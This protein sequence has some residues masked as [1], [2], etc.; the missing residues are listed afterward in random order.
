LV[1]DLYHIPIQ[2]R[3]YAYL[4]NGVPAHIRLDFNGQSRWVDPACLLE[5]TLAEGLLIVDQ[6]ISPLFL[7]LVTRDVWT[8][9]EL[10]GIPL[11]R[12]IC[13]EKGHPI[14]VNQD[15][16]GIRDFARKCSITVHMLDAMEDFS[17]REVLLLMEERLADLIGRLVVQV[18][19]SKCDSIDTGITRITFADEMPFHEF[20]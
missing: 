18:F 6:D 19:G 5:D 7:V 8:S 17:I 20:H 15:Q 10:R 4:I 13:F 1:D 16:N 14:L 3:K 12:L 9:G 11:V 2:T